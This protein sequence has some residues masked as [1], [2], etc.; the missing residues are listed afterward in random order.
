MGAPS[1]CAGGP[2]VLSRIL[3]PICRGRST[4]FPGKSGAALSGQ[5][6]AAALKTSQNRVSSVSRSRNSSRLLQRGP[7]PGSGAPP[8]A[9]PRPAP[10]RQQHHQPDRRVAALPHHAEAPGIAGLDHLVAGTGPTPAAL[11]PHGHGQRPDQLLGRGLV[12]GSGRPEPRQLLP[13]AVVPDILRRPGQGL[14]QRLPGL[15]A[16]APAAGYSSP[17]KRS[18]AY[19]GPPPPPCG[20]GPGSSPGSAGR[21]ARPTA[22]RMSSSIRSRLPLF[23]F[24]PLSYRK[25]SADW[26]SFRQR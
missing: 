8:S 21:R 11:Q 20:T 14:G 7:A 5:A 12:P 3:Y 22:R 19:R 23:R 10:D 13:V 9:P 15:S 16:A 17:G 24:C 6:S 2:G 18:P 25:I 1:F 4:A 26:E